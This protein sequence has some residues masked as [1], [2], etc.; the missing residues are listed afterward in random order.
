[1]FLITQTKNPINI[2]LGKLSYLKN[3][4][5]ILYKAQNLQSF[6]IKEVLNNLEKTIIDCESKNFH[7]VSPI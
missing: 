5:Y 4:I 3:F 2:F 7:G 1:M 6:Y